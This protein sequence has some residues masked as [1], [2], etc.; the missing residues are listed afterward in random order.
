MV[1]FTIVRGFDAPREVVWRAWTEPEQLAQWFGPRGISTPLD[2]IRMDLRPGGQA[3][4]VMVD[5]AS[6]VEYLNTGTYLEIVPPERLVWKD[7]GF[8]D[9]T[10]PGT[11][12]VTLRDLGGKTELTVH[13]VADFT[14]T[15]RAQAEVGWGSSFDKLA[16]LLS[17]R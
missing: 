13:V 1:E 17:R 5:D 15:M 6:G 9:G 7:D 16:E 11:V 10:G 2:K 14:E 4:L 3:S 12:T 8:S